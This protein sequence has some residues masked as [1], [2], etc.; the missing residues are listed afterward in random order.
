MDSMNCLGEST[1][2]SLKCLGGVLCELFELFEV[3]CL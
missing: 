2:K 3:Y 1:V